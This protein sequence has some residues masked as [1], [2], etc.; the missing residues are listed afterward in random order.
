MSKIELASQF[1][2]SAHIGSP[3]SQSVIEQT[4][5]LASDPLTT[6]PELKAYPSP[7]HPSQWRVPCQFCGKDH[8]HGVGE[9][10]RLAHCP[11]TAP[12]RPASGVYNS[13]GLAMVL[14]PSRRES[15]QRR[16]LGRLEDHG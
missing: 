10:L 5:P 3:L 2:T 16:Y 7:H 6:V 1:V 12:D 4:D 8:Y 9:G 11:P 15:R 14:C 13:F